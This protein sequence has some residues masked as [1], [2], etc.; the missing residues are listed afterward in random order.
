[1]SAFIVGD[2]HITAMIQTLS[3]RYPGDGVSYYWNGESHPVNG[4]SRQI[5]QVLV[6]E[7]YR[8]VNSRYSESGEPR[9]FKYDY[10][11]HSKTPVEIIKACHCYRYQA[12]ETK[13]WDKSEA[14]AIVNLIEGRATRDLPGYEDAEWE[15]RN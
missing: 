4:K 14:A 2:K 1:M 7:N 9:T 6:D 5:G 12:C 11:V 13:D 8:S 3:P 10:S 15:I